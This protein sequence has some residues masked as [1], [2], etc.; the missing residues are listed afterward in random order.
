MTA[1]ETTAEERAVWRSTED[2]T[3]VTSFYDIDLGRLVRDFDRAF[4]AGREAEREECARLA[5]NEPEPSGPIPDE[6][7]LA[8]TEDVALAAVRATKTAIA[9]AIR[10]RADH[11]GKMVGQP[12]PDTGAR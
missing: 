7:Q 8:S 4:A 12:S 11:A 6:L 2:T 10:A 9:V 3:G 1:L 5:E